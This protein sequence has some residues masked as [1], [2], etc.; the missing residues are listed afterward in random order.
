M[1]DSDFAKQKHTHAGTVA[2]RD[3]GP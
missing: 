3:F 2:F 1:K